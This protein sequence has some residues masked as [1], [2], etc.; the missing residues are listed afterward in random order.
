MAEPQHDVTP[1]PIVEPEYTI[2]EQQPETVVI[3][4]T[5]IAEPIEVAKPRVTDF[6]AKP[7]PMCVALRPPNTNFSRVT[8]T[9]REGSSVIRYCKCG[10][11]GWT[12]KD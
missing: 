2:T 1:L 3:T 8:T 12:F 5:E 9:R 7:C 6:A 11:C 10:F 4:G